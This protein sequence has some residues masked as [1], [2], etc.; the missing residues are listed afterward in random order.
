MK[1]S[2]AKTKKI[3]WK[4][5]KGFIYSDV[6]DFPAASAIVF[7]V[8][9]SHGRV[10]S[11]VCNRIYYVLGGRGEFIIKGKNIPVEKSDVIIVPKNTPYD[12]RAT[13]G[14]LRLF[15]VHCPAFDPEAEVKLE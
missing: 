4:G 3:G 12:Y 7:E 1:F 6:K 13:K 8:T 14:K 10:K 11:R 9:G 15:L 5:L 2:F